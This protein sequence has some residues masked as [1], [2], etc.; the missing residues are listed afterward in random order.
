MRKLEVFV[1]G[2][3]MVGTKIKEVMGNGDVMAGA[4][5]MG[6]LRVVVEMREMVRVG[7]RVSKEFDAG[8]MI[9]KTRM[10]GS[11]RAAGRT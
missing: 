3:K 4:K 11:A 8:V 5:G 6:E 10:T 2:V 7:R 9:V 1:G